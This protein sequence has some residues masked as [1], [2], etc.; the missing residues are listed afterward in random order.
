MNA[1]KTKFG[2]EYRA[3]L[4]DT[5]QSRRETLV[6]EWVEGRRYAEHAESPAL[7]AH[8]IDRNRGYV[9]DRI[10]LAKHSKCDTIHEFKNFVA[11]NDLESMEDFKEWRGLSTSRSRRLAKAATQ[12]DPTNVSVVVPQQLRDAMKNRYGYTADNIRKTAEKV[13][14][15]VTPE[16]FFACGLALGY[17]AK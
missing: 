15:N 17:E 1:D 7:I 4:S 16:V 14:D 11:D 12:S 13:L 6:K 8:D 9:E 10:N 2:D 5:V 3:V